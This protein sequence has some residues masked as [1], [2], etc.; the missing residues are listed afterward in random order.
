MFVPHQANQRI[1]EAACTR[2]GIPPERT[3]ANL[4]RWGNTSGA[5]IPIALAEATESGRLAPGDVVLLAGFGAG[6][7]WA[8]ALLRWG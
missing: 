1:I 3:F 7:S 5:S 6:M 8:S 4:D 2:L